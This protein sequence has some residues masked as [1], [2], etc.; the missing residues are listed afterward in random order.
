MSRVLTKVVVY[1]EGEARP[2]IEEVFIKF[3]K[4]DYLDKL[5]QAYLEQDDN[6]TEV[7]FESHEL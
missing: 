2:D 5:K 4:S 3:D 7:H 1:R 6:I